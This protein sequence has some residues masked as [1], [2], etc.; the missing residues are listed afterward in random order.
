MELIS[1]N[2]DKKSLIFGKYKLTKII[3]SGS[4]G[5]VYQG[6]NVIDNKLVAVKVEKKE[7]RYNL[8]EKESFCLYSLKGIGVP[9]VISYGYSG[10]YNVLVQTLLGE[11]LGK[12]FSIATACAIPGMLS[13]C[14]ALVEFINAPVGINKILLYF[15][16]SNI[17]IIYPQ[18]T[19]A[20]QAQPDPPLWVSW[21]FLSKIKT[22]QSL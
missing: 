14:C 2:G 19:L 7:K 15:F 9:E 1:K 11:S 5:Y 17:F 16:S 22:P 8:L 12:I 3:G 18:K 13:P 6:E 10:K 21:E 20:T 4:F